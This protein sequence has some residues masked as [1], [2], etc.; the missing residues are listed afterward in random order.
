MM[1]R[2]KTRWMFLLSLIL[3]LTAFFVVRGRDA[4]SASNFVGTQTCIDCHNTW[5]DNNPPIRV[6]LSR[7]KSARI[8]RL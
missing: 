6:R 4:Q 8:I 5:L 7:V 2:P 3:V 1:G